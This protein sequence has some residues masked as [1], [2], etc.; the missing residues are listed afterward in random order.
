M[1]KIKE[2]WIDDIAVYAKTEDGKVAYYLFSQWPSLSKATKAEREDFFLSYS[3]IH[4]PQL[5]EDLSF[6]GMF[7]NANLCERTASEDS[8]VYLAEE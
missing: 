4:W 1:V 8:V 2:V 3:G 7:S 5:D 6:E